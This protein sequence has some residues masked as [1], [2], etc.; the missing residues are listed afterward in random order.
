MTVNELI[1][2]AEKMRDIENSV[3]NIK[4]EIVGNVSNLAVLK[5][6]NEPMTLEDLITA[7]KNPAIENMTGQ[8]KL[9]T[10]FNSVFPKSPHDLDLR[11][12]MGIGAS[13]DN[14]RELY[15]LVNDNRKQSFDILGL[16]DFEVGDIIRNR[17][18]GKFGVIKKCYREE[19][20]IKYHLDGT[21]NNIHTCTNPTERFDKVKRRDDGN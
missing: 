10:L 19:G 16:F 3:L 6:E 12:V 4:V 5:W 1:A 7:L 15:L 21:P 13:E 18:T 17:K 20:I 8:E 14:F 11:N 2:N 9:V